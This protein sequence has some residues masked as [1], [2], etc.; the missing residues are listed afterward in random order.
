MERIEAHAQRKNTS[1]H[2]QVQQKVEALREVRGPDEAHTRVFRLEAIADLLDAI[3]EAEG[4]EA[5]DRLE[6]KKV[7]EL[8]AIAQDKNVEGASDMKKADLIQAIRNAESEE[9]NQENADEEEG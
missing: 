5:P 1:E 4:R 2:K 8:K 7:P 9:G 3:E 6:V